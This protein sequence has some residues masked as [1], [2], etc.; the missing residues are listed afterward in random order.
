MRVLWIDG[1]VRGACSR[2]RRLAETFLNALAQ[3]RADVQIETACLNELGL[4]PFNEETLR[5][6]DGAADFSGREFEAARQFR[7]ADLLVFAAPFWEGTFPAALHTYLEH[8]CV[9]GLTFRLTE[10]GYEG[11]CHAGRAV[12]LTTRGGI[13]ESGPAVRDNHAAAFLTTVLTMLGVPRLDTVAAEG[14]DIEGCDVEA[15]L[16]QA[17]RQACDLAQRIAADR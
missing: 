15:A 6:R 5:E 10:K 12:F 2:T 17:E 9:T 3:A 16:V 1:C 4:V 11:L 14:L 8:V 13:Y 7:E